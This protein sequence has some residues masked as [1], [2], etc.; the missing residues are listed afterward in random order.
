MTNGLDLKL[1]EVKIYSNGVD[2][3]LAS[4]SSQSSTSGT[5][6]SSLAHDG[7]TNTY[8]LTDDSAAWWSTTLA[9]SGYVDTIT[10]WADFSNCNLE[11]AVMTLSDN[12]DN[13][14]ATRTLNSCGIFNELFQPACTGK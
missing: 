11:G 13:I 5:Q 1:K 10:I 6:I 8:S 12:S 2:V 4:T 14:V 7:D 9:T 3:G